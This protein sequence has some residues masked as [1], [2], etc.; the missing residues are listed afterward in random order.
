MDYKTVP[1]DPTDEMHQAGVD[2]AEWHGNNV[3]RIYQAMVRA[4]PAMEGDQLISGLHESLDA[5]DEMIKQLKAEI[6]DL[7]QSLNDNDI[8]IGKL[9]AEH[10]AAFVRGLERAQEMLIPWLVCKCDPAYT[11]RGRHES[12]AWHELAEEIDAAI[13]AEIDKA[14]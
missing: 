3:V 13:Q 6:R 14:K 11:D 8:E 5:H 2:A 9:K 7:Y 12:N 4:A 10:D 1:L